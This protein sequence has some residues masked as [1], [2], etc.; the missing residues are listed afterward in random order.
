MMLAGVTFLVFCV[1]QVLAGQFGTIGRPG[2]GLRPV[3][4]RT[5]TLSTTVSRPS[6]L[7]SALIQLF[8]RNLRTLNW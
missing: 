2:R 8:F 3:D 6:I 5:R 1:G 4:V 7:P